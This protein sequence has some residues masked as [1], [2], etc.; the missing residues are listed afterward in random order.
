MNWK[1]SCETKEDIPLP[2][3]YTFPQAFNYLNP[4]VNSFYIL[5]NEYGYIQCAG[6]KQECTVE[7]R[8]FGK[9]GA[10]KH[11]VFFDPKGSDESVHI[12]MTNGGVH[13]Q[14]KHCFGFLTASKL[15]SCF[16]EGKDWPKEIEREDITSQFV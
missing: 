5:E 10:F 3:E 1:F 14:R 2:P 15:F 8:E 12:P 11:Y 4:E 13:R 9:D 16:F 7:I 6:A